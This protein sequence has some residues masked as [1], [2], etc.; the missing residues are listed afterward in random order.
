MSDDP[1]AEALLELP[2]DP[3]KYETEVE[4]RDDFI[5]SLSAPAGGAEQPSDRPGQRGWLFEDA[6]WEAHRD[7]FVAQVSAQGM[8]MVKYSSIHEGDQVGEL[9]VLTDPTGAIHVQLATGTYQGQS[10][11]EVSRR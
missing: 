7:A 8:S 11:I 2:D 9:Y 10:V 5:A 6:N 3:A 4:A 1:T